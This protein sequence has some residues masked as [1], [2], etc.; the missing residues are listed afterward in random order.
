MRCLGL[1]LQSS[2][3]IFL[4]FF[5]GWGGTLIITQRNIIQRTHI[6]YAF[7][8]NFLQSEITPSQFD[9]QSSSYDKLQFKNTR[10]FYKATI[11]VN[12]QSISVSQY[13]SIDIHNEPFF[14]LYNFQSGCYSENKLISKRVLFSD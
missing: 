3:L 6:Q 12:Q 9:S 7:A 5:W 2:L 1:N 13:P 10:H 8:T 4:T 11:Q 14:S